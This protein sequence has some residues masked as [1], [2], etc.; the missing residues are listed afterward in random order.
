MTTD[1]DFSALMEKAMEVMK[2]MRDNIVTT[3][4]I[5]S[6]FDR[7][8]HALECSMLVMTGGNGGGNG[9]DSDAD[10]VDIPGLAEGIM[11]SIADEADP[12]FSPSEIPGT[13]PSAPSPDGPSVSDA[14]LDDK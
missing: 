9:H 7:R 2:G 6:Q 13:E 1:A 5:I 12:D 10:P 3:S 11:D 14:I 8:I 4:T